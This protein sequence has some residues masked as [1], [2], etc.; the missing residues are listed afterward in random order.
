MATLASVLNDIGNAN[1]IIATTSSFQKGAKQLAEHN[2]IR[3]VLVNYLLKSIHI[4]S[5]PIATDFANVSFDFNQESI[6]EA[7]IR[8][9]LESYTANY[10]ISG[11]DFFLDMNGGEI[12]TINS[13]VRRS[14]KKEGPNIIEDV[15]MYLDIDNI[16]LVMVDSLAF[17]IIHRALPMM[18]SI[19]ES[20]HSAKAVIEDIVGNN[21]HYL[22]EDGSVSEN[23]DA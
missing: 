20:P 9:N 11:E 14:P 15:N 7:L 13:F 2:N 10:S 12:E 4:Q 16:G 21:I 1:G 5:H 22:H 17:D 6:R 23:I 3:L 8:N 18:E 19:I